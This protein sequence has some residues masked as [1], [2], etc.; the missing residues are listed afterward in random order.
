MADANS[1]SP[2]LA[3]LGAGGW[4]VTE[5]SAGGR[6]GSVGV[7]TPEQ[8][9]ATQALVSGGGKISDVPYYGASFGDSR[10][11][12]EINIFTPDFGS[13]T[14]LVRLNRVPGVIAAEM[15]DL[16][17][18]RNY[19]VSGEAAAAW[20]SSTRAIWGGPAGSAKFAN[21]LAEP[22][23]DVIFVQYGI[24]GVLGWD[25]VTPALATFVA[26]EV[27]YHKAY[28]AEAFKAGRRVVWEAINPCSLANFGGLAIKQTA[29]DQINAAMQAFIGQFPQWA[30]FADTAPA[31]KLD[32]FANPALY[33]DGLHFNRAGAQVSAKIVAAAARTLL[34]KKSAAVFGPL[35]LQPNFIDWLNPW[36]TTVAEAGAVSGLVTT[37]GVDGG[38]FFIQHVFTPT[39][40]TRFRMHTAGH[41]GTA[42]PRY[43]V[44]IGDVLQ[45]SARIVVDDGNGGPPNLSGL[46]L[47]HRM[48]GGSGIFSTSG[49]LSDTSMAP[50]SAVSQ[51]LFTPRVAS[52]MASASIADVG[53]SQGYTLETFTTHPGT[54]PVRVRIYSPQLRKVA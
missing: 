17:M 43:P 3:T 47:R 33:S 2:G 8:T 12:C 18:N 6:F 21:L 23:L 50:N 25:G 19:G 41:V 54:A 52:A 5:P 45:G 27:G 10:A 26:T 30:V 53:L 16:D 1:V 31:L 49:D 9:L 24:N 22:A 29:V 4:T 34:P 46:N 35:P 37:T 32:G 13:N 51:R 39:A 20:A 15:G 42:A 7:L 40:G 44:A 48:Y 38:E 36:I 14:A 11:L 28:L